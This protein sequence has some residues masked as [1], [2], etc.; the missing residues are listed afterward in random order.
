MVSEHSVLTQ[1]LRFSLYLNLWPQKP[2][3]YVQTTVF[4]GTEFSKLSIQ[5][6]LSTQIE[7]IYINNLGHLQTFTKPTTERELMIMSFYYLFNVVNTFTRV[8]LSPINLSLERFM[9][10]AK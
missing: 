10:N 9:V 5:G 8:A 4:D 1:W 7:D 6:S 3:G 2:T